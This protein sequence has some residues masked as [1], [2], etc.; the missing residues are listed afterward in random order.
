MSSVGR[1]LSIKRLKDVELGQRKSGGSSLP[2]VKKG[3]DDAKEERCILTYQQPTAQF[4]TSMFFMLYG[5]QPRVKCF[6]STNNCYNSTKKI[7]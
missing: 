1:D 4:K 6:K 2:H 7:P 5:N 3:A